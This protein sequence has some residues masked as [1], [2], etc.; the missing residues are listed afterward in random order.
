MKISQSSFW[1]Y[2][3]F[4]LSIC[5][6][7]GFESSISTTNSS[8]QQSLL[9]GLSC[10]AISWIATRPN[11]IQGLAGKLNSFFKPVEKISVSYY[12][13][14]IGPATPESLGMIR[15]IA[16][17][18]LIV[19]AL[20]F[21][22]MPRSALLPVSMRSNMGI[23]Q[24]FY[25]IP[26]FELFV[27]SEGALKVFE[28]LTVLVLFLG[29]IGWRT[30][31]VIPLGA[32][33]YL[34][35]GGIVRQY[36][37]FYHQGLIVVYLLGILSFTPCGDGLSVD[38]LLKVQR[39]Q[40]VP[41]ANR[42]LPIYGWSRYTCWVLLVL[43]YLASGG[44]KLY[45]SGLF[46]WDPVNLRGMM[47]GCSLYSCNNLFHWDLSLR[48][49]P[50][51]PDFVFALFGL[52]G[53]VGEIAFVT[54]LFSKLA[55]R[56]MP[57]VMVGLH[58][59]IGAF[60]N[61]LFIDFILLQLIFYDF[62]ELKHF[63][64]R[65]LGINRRATYPPQARAAATAPAFNQP[66]GSVLYPLMIIFLTLLIGFT[67][68]NRIKKYPFTGFH[69]FS[70]KDTSGVVFYNT[71][72]A[73]DGSG[74]T[75]RVYPE[76]MI[77]AQRSASYRNVTDGCFSGEPEEVQVCDDYLKALGSAHNQESQTG[78]KYTQLE[79][80]RWR[81]DFLTNPLD[82]NHGQQIEDYTVKLN[83]SGSKN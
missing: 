55:R 60:Q 52:V 67:W 38:R 4:A 9:F 46:W 17:I 42:P 71:F 63:V 83:V 21:E 10:G 70:Y 78:E 18:S 53:T 5:L 16:C 58:V 2:F 73:Q 79:L 45:D 26:G 56:I 57:I 47:Y 29:M 24:F 68:T 50:H 11:L 66:Q 32:F 31:V 7:T 49:G 81:W 62:A 64:T 23:M 48:F 20:W 25:F 3:I 77:G 43:S 61:I 51:L 76:K 39:G 40:P 36:F 72:H 6:W 8:L 80:K 82:P 37:Y 15:I 75:A 74:E 54:V 13:R 33:C 22:D 69:L 34:L 44:S 28:W 27:R 41:E 59:G 1:L 19:M 12:K 30:R 14:F 35:L 65:G